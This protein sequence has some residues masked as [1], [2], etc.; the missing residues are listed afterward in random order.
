MKREPHVSQILPAGRNVFFF[1]P[2][3]NRFLLT[4]TLKEVV[5]R[6]N[7]E[8][9]LA[10]CRSKVI[11]ILGNTVHV[12]GVGIGL[13]AGNLASKFRDAQFDDSKY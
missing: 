5:I 8:L 10:I 2:K 4:W 7:S 13:E 3:K 6:R 11:K 9:T 12:Y 1:V